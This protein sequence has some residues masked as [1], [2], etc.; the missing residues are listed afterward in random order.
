MIWGNWGPK[1]NRGC[2]RS[3]CPGPERQGTWRGGGRPPEPL[4]WF[5]AGGRTTLWTGFSK[6]WRLGLTLCVWEVKEGPTRKVRLGPVSRLPFSFFLG[7]WGRWPQRGLGQSPKRGAGPAAT[8]RWTDGHDQCGSFFVGA[9]KTLV[10]GRNNAEREGRPRAGFT[11][12]P[13][14]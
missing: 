2:R 3:G 10:N 4:S 7:V 6:W 9:W 11:G 13:A 8:G 14:R 5:E 12:P 1:S